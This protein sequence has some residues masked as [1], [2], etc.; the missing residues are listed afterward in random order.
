MATIAGMRRKP[1]PPPPGWRMQ[2]FEVVPGLF[3]GTT[4][5]ASAQ[6][7]TIGVDAIIDLEDWEFAWVPPVP[8]GSIYLS[9][10]ME[11]EERVDPKVRE[12]AA[13]AASLVRS[14]RK[15]LVH[16]TEGLNRSG[17]VAARALLELGCTAEDAIALIRRKRGLTSDGFPALSNERFVEWLLAEGGAAG[18]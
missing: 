4:L 13:F 17:V 2:I 5:A 6:Y 16:C 8:T 1:S 7:P 9:F 14:G 3:I 10:P 18:H 15:V 12:V 11:D